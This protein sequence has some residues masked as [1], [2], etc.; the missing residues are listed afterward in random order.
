MKT[1]IS[2]AQIWPDFVAQGVL[3]KGV[4]ASK[5][6]YGVIWPR[7]SGERLDMYRLLLTS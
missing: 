4:L 6:K 7:T 2:T 3:G 1:H 5:N